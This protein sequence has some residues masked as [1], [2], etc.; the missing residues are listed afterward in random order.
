MDEL[1]IGFGV[2]SKRNQACWQRLANPLVRLAHIAPPSPICI[3]RQRPEE[4]L[5]Q[6]AEAGD[7]NGWSQSCRADIEPP[8]PTPARLGRSKKQ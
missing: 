2:A 8:R 1:L 6:D 5:I 4:F 3:G 7:L